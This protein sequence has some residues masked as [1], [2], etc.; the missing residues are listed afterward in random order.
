MPKTGVGWCAC[1]ARSIAI[2]SRPQGGGRSGIRRR[3]ACPRCGERWT[4]V[5]MRIEDLQQFSNNAIE[6]AIEMLQKLIVPV[7]PE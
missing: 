3:R 7:G 2:E 4:T 1:G 6:K 5:E